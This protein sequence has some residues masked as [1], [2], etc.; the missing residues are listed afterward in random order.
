MMDMTKPDASILVT[1]ASITIAFGIPILL[2]RIQRENQMRAEQERV[3]LPWSDW[4][5]LIAVMSSLLF[6]L[7]PT[8]GGYIPSFSS[9]VSVA[10][11]ICLAGYIP[12]ILAHYRIMFGASRHGPRNNPEPMERVFV[13]LTAVA[14][15]GAFIFL[16]FFQQPFPA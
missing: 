6:V 11:S 2:Y 1:I 14:A 4:P 10:S 9:A 12:S 16:Y 13:I 7:V 3:W 15:I 8:A 5:L